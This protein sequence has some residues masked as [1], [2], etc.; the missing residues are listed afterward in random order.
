MFDKI[1]R[2]LEKIK[3][4]NNNNDN[5]KVEEKEVIINNEEIKDFDSLEL[6]LSS[7]EIYEKMISHH[8]VKQISD[9]RLDKRRI[10]LANKIMREEFEG[11]GKI[12]EREIKKDEKQIT[13]LRKKNDDK[14]ENEVEEEEEEELKRK[15]KMKKNEEE[16]ILEREYIDIEYIYRIG[17]LVALLMIKEQNNRVEFHTIYEIIAKL[18]NKKRREVA[19]FA[20]LEWS[21][22]YIVLNILDMKL[23]RKRTEEQRELLNDNEDD[24]IDMKNIIVGFRHDTYKNFFLLRGLERELIN[25]ETLRDDENFGISKT[26]KSP[27][28]R[29][30][31]NK[32]LNNIDLVGNQG[33]ENNTYLYDKN[34]YREREGEKVG[35]RVGGEEGAEEKKRIVFSSI[36][37]VLGRK[38]N[39]FNYELIKFIGDD[40]RFTKKKNLKEKLILLLNQQ[41]FNNRMERLE[42]LAG[43]YFKFLI[44]INIFFYYIFI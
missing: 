19:R 40:I 16:N 12:I 3:N 30:T 21:I 5:N 7:Y 42:K 11:I 2:K 41:Q 22:L 25:Y 38:E 36:E 6:R 28:E 29:N 26:E 13:K 32:Y 1:M 44:F 39:L 34:Q 37:Y 17:E 15:Q 35:G 33:Y 10:K 24:G 4:N 18:R 23:E 43:K 27:E 8:I 9:L 14:K 31:T 20:R